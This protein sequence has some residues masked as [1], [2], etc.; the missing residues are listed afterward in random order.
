MN[1]YKIEKQISKYIEGYVKSFSNFENA[2]KKSFE[3]KI[4]IFH[5]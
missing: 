4:Q 1:I 2:D 5:A 3:R